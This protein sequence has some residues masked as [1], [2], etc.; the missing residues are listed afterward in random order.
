[1]AVTTLTQL[2]PEVR[3]Y[4]DRLLLALARPYYIYDLFAQKRQIPL[5]SGDQMIFRRYGTL[6]AATVPLTDGQTPPGDQLSV[7]DFSTQIQWYGSFVTITDQV[8]YVVQDRVLNEATKVLSLQ[9]G[10][11]LDT[12]IRDMMVSTA[13]VIFC[14]N[15]GNGNTPT[16]ITD[17]DIQTAVI[18]L[19]QG[20]ARLMTNPLPGELKIGTAPIRSSYW[21]FMSVDL[22]DDLEAVSSFISAANYP[23]PMNALEAEWGSTRNVRWL[24]N[25]NGYSTSASPPV[26]SNFVL[27][28][29]AYGVVRLGAKEAEFIVKPLGASGTADPLNQRGTVGYK[30]PFAT[31]ILNDNW[32]TRLISTHS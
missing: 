9:L 23:N 18:A 20:N 7:T 8:Q 6:T 25:T 30:Y 17:E 11:T 13:S 24:L 22:Q 28:Q 16:E 15:G 21:G 32:I 12:L 19:R 26:Y 31:R 2:P 29:E 3:Q 14:T 5:N 4:F 10:L 27:G 1:M